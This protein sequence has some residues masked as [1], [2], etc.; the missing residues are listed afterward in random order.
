MKLD[1]IRGLVLWVSISC[2]KSVL[3]LNDV[4]IV[5]TMVWAIPGAWIKICRY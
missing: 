3:V 4:V 1:G 5:V 2:L